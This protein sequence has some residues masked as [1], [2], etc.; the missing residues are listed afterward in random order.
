MGGG[1]TG[2]LGGVKR[3]PA[4]A[5]DS[6]TFARKLKIVLTCSTTGTIQLI[7]TDVVP[8][9]Q[10]VPSRSEVINVTAHRRLSYGV[11]LSEAK[12]KQRPGGSSHHHGTDSRHGPGWL[13][14]RCRLSGVH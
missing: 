1:V 5:Q 11:M 8:A 2:D 7:S 4:A 13:S 10:S 9:A 12:T 14:S 6:L 3:M